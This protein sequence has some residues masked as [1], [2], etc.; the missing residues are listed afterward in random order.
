MIAD[1]SDR[2]TDRPSRS[3]RLHSIAF[4][5]LV[6]GVRR[7]GQTSKL[8]SGWSCIAE[9]IT[10]RSLSC[11][12]P[13]S[14]CAVATAERGMCPG[15]RIAP[16]EGPG[17][18]AACPHAENR[19]GG[20]IVQIWG[21]GGHVVARPSTHSSILPAAHQDR[22]TVRECPAGSP[23]SRSA[24]GVVAIGGAGKTCFQPACDRTLAAS[25]LGI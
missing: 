25:V 2:Q 21:E 23:A 9:G 6:A 18:R 3:R 10:S 7:A 20:R 12:S 15:L 17:Q 19:S 14:S 16:V 8:I 13:P 22:A 11:V 5:T 1:R 4:A 24:G